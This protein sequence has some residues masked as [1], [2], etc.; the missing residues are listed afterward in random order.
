M[1]VKRL[2]DGKSRKYFIDKLTSYAHR[3]YGYNV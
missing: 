1:N 2:G 3:Y